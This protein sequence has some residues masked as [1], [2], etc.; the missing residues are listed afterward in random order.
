MAAETAAFPVWCWQPLTLHLRTP[1][2]VAYGVSATRTVWWL[3]LADDEGWGESAIPPYYGIA[4]ADQVAYW[5]ARATE[6]RPLPTD[7]ADIG[8]WVGEEGPA[9]AR[10]ALDLAL[11]DRLARHHDLPLYRLLG[12]PPPPSLPTS[13]TISLADPETMA[14]EAAAAA[15][16]PILKIKLGG[17]DDEACVAAVRHARPEARLRLDA[18]GAWSPEEAV[19]RLRALTRFQP[20]LIEQPVTKDDIEGLGFVQAHTPV[21]VVADESLCTAADLERLAAVGVAGINLKL[22]KVGGLA[23]ALR[24]LRRAR[25]LG[26]KVLLG[27]MIETSLGVTAAFHLAALADWLDLDSPLLIANDPFRGVLYDSAGRMTLPNRAGIGVILRQ[28]HAHRHS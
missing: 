1:F 13:L 24:L 25:A 2:R 23:P 11:H 16:Y 15:T 5:Q 10:A 4:D 17:E 26:M 7:P 6:R 3:R 12:L 14:R 28:N 9:P 19:R 18:N 27:C 21:P 8:V 20:E 22:M